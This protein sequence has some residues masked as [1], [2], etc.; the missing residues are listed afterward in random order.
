MFFVA[1]WGILFLQLRLECI[2]IGMRVGVM[3]VGA[4]FKSFERGTK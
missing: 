2:R 3:A 1:I 4:V